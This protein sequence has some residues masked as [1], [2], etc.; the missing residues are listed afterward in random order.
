MTRLMKPAA[1][2]HTIKQLNWFQYETQTFNFTEK[3]IMKRF[4][5]IA[6]VVAGLFCVSNVDSAE[7][8]GKKWG[9]HKTTDSKELEWRTQQFP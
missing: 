1:L 2:S 8:G 5:L 4:F 6:A 7:A 9:G 3:L